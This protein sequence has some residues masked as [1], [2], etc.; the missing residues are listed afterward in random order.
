MGMGMWYK[1]SIIAVGDEPE[2]FANFFSGATTVHTLAKDAGQRGGVYSNAT[3]RWQLNL[4]SS[5][6][7]LWVRYITQ[8]VA[9]FSSTNPVF[10]ISNYSTNKDALRLH[11]VS[12]NTYR[13]TYNSSGTTYT[14]I[15]DFS[16]P[17][18]NGTIYNS[19]IVIYFKRGA[20]GVLKMWV[21]DCLLVDLSGNYSTVDA[22]F[23]CVRFGGYSTSTTTAA[24]QPLGGVILSDESPHGKTINHISPDNTGNYSSWTGSY[25]ALADNTGAP[26][27][28]TTTTISVNANSQKFT[29]SYEDLSALVSER[30]VEAVQLAA[31]GIIEA[32][33][34]PSAV[35]FISRLS[36]T[37]YTHDSLLL[38]ST[39]SSYKQVFPLDPL[40]ASWTVTNIN[41]IEFGVT[42]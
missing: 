3:N 19:E 14:T 10:A 23:N 7:E 22:T 33:S 32:A 9:G 37:D 35:Y 38:S 34:T 21:D 17:T 20:S 39:A 24:S 18:S 26:Q 12:A 40:G 15:V 16:Y 36:S 6:T 27:I 4:T 28:D 11:A 41:S 29:T 25:T 42:T 5:A 1:M 8:G 30:E 13:F 2:C 31:R